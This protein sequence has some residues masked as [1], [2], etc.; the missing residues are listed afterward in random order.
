MVHLLLSRPHRIYPSAQGKPAASR[1]LWRQMWAR[2]LVNSLSDQNLQ[3]IVAQDLPSKD[4]EARRWTIGNSFYFRVEPLRAMSCENRAI[5]LPSFPGTRGFRMITF[6]PFSLLHDCTLMAKIQ[7]SPLEQRNMTTVLFLSI[8]PLAFLRSRGSLYLLTFL[9]LFGQGKT[10]FQ[11]PRVVIFCVLFKNMTSLNGYYV[12]G[13][14]GD[15]FPQM[16]STPILTRQ[17]VHGPEFGYLN[18]ISHSS[19]W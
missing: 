11:L 6:I 16:E 4:R 7:L 14:A 1:R 15:I 18:F 8:G 9:L 17:L 2:M 12:C 13:T 5:N 10:F 19:I 3:N